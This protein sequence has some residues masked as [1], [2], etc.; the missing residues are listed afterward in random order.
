MFVTSIRT[1]RVFIGICI[2]IFLVIYFRSL[3]FKSEPDS[4]ANY[5]KISN[6][7]PCLYGFRAEI[8]HLAGDLDVVVNIGYK[9]PDWLFMTANGYVANTPLSGGHSILLESAHPLDLGH[10]VNLK[11]YLQDT[12]FSLALSVLHMKKGQV[13]LYHVGEG[14]V[15]VKEVIFASLDHPSV[16]VH[17]VTIQ[18]PRQQTQTVTVKAGVD[19][20][21]LET[22]Q[23]IQVSGKTGVVYS[24]LVN[25]KH[26]D[27]FVAA[28]AHLLS[29]KTIDIQAGEQGKVQLLVSLASDKLP[30]VGERSEKIKQVSTLAQQGLEKVIAERILSDHVLHWEEIRRSGLRLQPLQD[31][32]MAKPLEVNLTMYYLLT[33]YRPPETSKPPTATACFKG[34][35][36]SHSP[37]LWTKVNSLDAAFT[38]LNAWATVL[39]NGGCGEFTAS[40]RL[41]FHQALLRSFAGLI[42]TVH[43]MELALNPHSMEGYVTLWGIDFQDVFINLAVVVN[44]PSHTGTVSVSKDPKYGDTALYACDQICKDQIISLPNNGRDVTFPI[45][46]TN[47]ATPILYVALQQ[48]QLVTLRELIEEHHGLDLHSLEEHPISSL[49]IIMIAAVI[50]VFHALLFHMVYKEFCSGDR[51]HNK[52]AR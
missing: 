22:I 50:L 38:K 21:L 33:L 46:P 5:G 27:S 41:N 17:D 51:G 26:G 25:G 7:P 43:G 35:P 3:A 15:V 44:T 23:N 29:H 2:F 31:H 28:A 13:D 14:C 16:I 20:H 34:S 18:S 12:A 30:D 45:R 40:T 37:V 42:Q 6:F 19:T 52:D 9:T 24:D 36:S 4:I 11:Y 48:D 39:I 47:P 32:L 10:N 49:F 8:E 1:R